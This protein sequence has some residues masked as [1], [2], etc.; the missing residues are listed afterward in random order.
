MLRA[1]FPSFFFFLW[2]SAGAPEPSICQPFGLGPGSPIR[3]PLL[4]RSSSLRLFNPKETWRWRS[5]EGALERAR[6]TSVPH[7]LVSGVGGLFGWSFNGC[8]LGSLSGGQTLTCRHLFISF[9][10][11]LL[12]AYYAQSMG[13]SNEQTGMPALGELP[14][15]HT[16]THTRPPSEAQRGTHKYTRSLS[17]I[18]PHY[19]TLPEGHRPRVQPLMR[20]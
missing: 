16:H 6:A 12:N 15:Q 20:A 17:R 4:P 13:Q 7:P 8:F 19:P 2:L 18:Q 5:G 10:K 11:F 14:V 9:Y 1:H 3:Q